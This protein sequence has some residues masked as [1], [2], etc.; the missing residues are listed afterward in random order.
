MSVLTEG[1][2]EVTP[3]FQCGFCGHD[4]RQGVRSEPNWVHVGQGGSP[5]HNA[6]PSEAAVVWAS[7]R[8]KPTGIGSLDMDGG[9]HW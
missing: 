8:W 5:L 6:T 1:V 7:A 9:L 2:P 3:I 4:I